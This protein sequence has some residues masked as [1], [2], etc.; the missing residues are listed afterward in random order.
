[1]NHLKKLVLKVSLSENNPNN[2]YLIIYF[3]FKIGTTEK[4]FSENIDELEL[5]EKLIEDE[6]DTVEMSV[7]QVKCFKDLL[8]NMKTKFH[9]H[10][11]TKNEKLQILSLLP[12][13]WKYEDIKKHFVV[14]EYMIRL[15]KKLQT[16]NGPMSTLAFASKGML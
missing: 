13:S 15:S 7:D 12:L 6:I 11:T 1:M 8:E 10:A 2:N 5:V 3:Y 14:S 4:G 16:E 9:D